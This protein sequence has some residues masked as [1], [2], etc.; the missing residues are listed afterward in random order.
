MATLQ[1]ELPMSFDFRNPDHWLQ[2][3]R[4]FEEY[5]SVTILDKESETWQVN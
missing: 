3:E 1:L 2:W 4:L 5:R